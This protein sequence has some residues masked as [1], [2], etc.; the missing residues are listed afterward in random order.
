VNVPIV[1]IQSF[2][3]PRC[4]MLVAL[5]SVSSGRFRPSLARYPESIDP[6]PTPTRVASFRESHITSSEQVGLCISGVAAVNRK[7]RSGLFAHRWNRN[8]NLVSCSASR[9][10]PA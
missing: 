6:L 1:N 8:V 10:G 2:V 4:A 3:D 9:C 5:L 7:S